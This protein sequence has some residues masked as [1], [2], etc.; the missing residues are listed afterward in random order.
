MLDA[1]L[2]VQLSSAD[3]PAEVGSCSCVDHHPV[4]QTPQTLVSELGLGIA[5][6]VDRGGRQASTQ[7]DGCEVELHGKQIIAT[8]AECVK[9]RY[10]QIFAQPMISLLPSNREAR[11]NSFRPSS[12][13]SE[14]HTA[15]T[16]TGE[17]GVVLDR[18]HD[19]AILFCRAL[20]FIP[21]LLVLCRFFVDRSCPCPFIL[22][23][24]VAGGSSVQ[25]AS[26]QR[27][28]AVLASS[29]GGELH[30]QRL[31]NLCRLVLL[32]APSCVSSLCVAVMC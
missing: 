14:V 5:V 8:L 19:P 28:L 21:R 24:L 6:V 2:Y 26:V 10:L 17:A 13:Q 31:G 29:S 27:A 3:S 1:S 22:P 16:T 18:L 32:D 30:C 25:P 7:I 11:Y 15:T 20:S 12:A 4:V 9:Y 23:D